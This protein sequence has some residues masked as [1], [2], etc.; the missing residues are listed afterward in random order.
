[1]RYLFERHETDGG[2]CRS[3]RDLIDD[4]AAL[5]WMGREPLAPGEVLKAFRGEGVVPFARRMF[6]NLP[7]VL[8]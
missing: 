4:D 5:E 8:A 7:D 1:M 2:L 3:E 6:Q